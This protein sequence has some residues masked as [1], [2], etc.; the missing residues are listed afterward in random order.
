MQQPRCAAQ[1]L[2][3]LLLRCADAHRVECD[4][5]DDDAGPG[6]YCSVTTPHSEGEEYKFTCPVKVC[7]CGGWAS[8]GG[9]GWGG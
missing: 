1:P 7:V 2:L 3:L 6:I 8:G 4:T 9:V 5:I